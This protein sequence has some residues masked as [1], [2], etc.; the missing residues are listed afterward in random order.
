MTT[1]EAPYIFTKFADSINFSSPSFN[2]IEFTTDFPCTHFKPAS[3]TSHLEESIMIG[4]RAISGSDINKFRNWGIIFTPSIIPSSM[5]ISKICAPPSTCS[6]ATEIASSNFSSRIK[7][8]NFFDPVTLQRSPI[9]TNLVNSVISKGSKP[10]NCWFSFATGITCGLCL[11]AT[12]AI[13]SIC[14]GVVPQQ[15][16]II[17]KKPF[18]KK[19]SIITAISEGDW[20]YS[21]I[22]FGKPALGCAE[23][24]KGDLSFK[25]FT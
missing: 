3:I 11:A 13:A 8:A 4:K 10:D 16:P 14:A 18:S 21:P 5:L 22:S 25:V 20:S 9:L 6:R 12:S 23:T 19:S 15:P 24:K 1:T 7:R 17:F 2:E